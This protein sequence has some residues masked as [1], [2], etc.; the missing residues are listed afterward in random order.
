MNYQQALEIVK[1][2][3]KVQRQF[4]KTKYLTLDIVLLLTDGYSYWYYGWKPSQKDRKAT[5]WKEK[6][7]P[8]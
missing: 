8:K 7:P 2:G 5:D 1:H 4:W 3:G 6:A